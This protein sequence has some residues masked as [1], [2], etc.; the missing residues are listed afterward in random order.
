MFQDLN[1]ATEFAIG[2]GTM[3]YLTF[4]DGVWTVF[5]H[6]WTMLVSNRPSRIGQLRVV[7]SRA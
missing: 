6:A 3:F 2:E 1:T 4:R 7:N 5:R